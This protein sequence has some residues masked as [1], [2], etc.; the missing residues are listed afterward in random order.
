MKRL[1]KT[2]SAAAALL[3]FACAGMWNAPPAA[4]QSG[5]PTVLFDGTNLDNFN[6]V[7]DANW[8]IEDGAVVADKGV[9]FLVSKNSYADYQLRIE[10]WADD[11]VNSGIYMRC[12]NPAEPTDKTCYEANIYDKRPDPTFGTGAIVHLAKIESPMKVGGKW[13]TYEITAKGPEIT[14][15]LN[16]QTTVKGLKDEQLKSGPVALQYGE[17]VVKGKGVIKFRK[18]EIRAL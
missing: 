2:H 6:K 4:A 9:G 11:D 5:G 10:F 16:G 14:V 3:A 17:S 18:V 12:S 8:R 15:V 13:N 7:G 1:S